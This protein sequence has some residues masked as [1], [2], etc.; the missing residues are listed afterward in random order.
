[1]SDTKYLS[2]QELKKFLKIPE[3][4]DFT[5]VTNVKKIIKDELLKR[6]INTEINVQIEEKGASAVIVVE[7]EPFQT[8]PVLF[9]SLKV[10]N[11]TSFIYANQKDNLVQFR[12]DINIEYVLFGAKQRTN[13]FGLFSLRGVILPDGK[14]TEPVIDLRY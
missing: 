13:I 12:L 3:D 4:I 6:G 11:S 8:Q 7:S 1:M 2:L 9:N 14:I 10:T 5:L